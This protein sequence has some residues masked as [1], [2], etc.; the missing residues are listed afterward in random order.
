MDFQTSWQ[1]YYVILQHQEKQQKFV[2]QTEKILNNVVFWTFL[3][4]GSD[5]F[6][7]FHIIVKD[8]GAHHLSQITIFRKLFKGD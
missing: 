1:T 6:F 7:I 4:N 3:E 8:N 2:S 5:E